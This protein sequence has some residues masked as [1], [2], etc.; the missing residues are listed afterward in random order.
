MNKNIL[1]FFLVL[2]A[3]LVWLGTRNLQLTHRNNEA[4]R[5]WQKDS[6]RYNQQLEEQQTVISALK[7]GDDLILPRDEGLP[8]TLA[9]PYLSASQGVE[10]HL[11]G[12]R[13]ENRWFKPNQTH[14][15]EQMGGMAEVQINQIVFDPDFARAGMPDLNVE[16]TAP[17]F[18]E[19]K[20]FLGDWLE[21]FNLSGFLGKSF[22]DKKPVKTYDLNTT[23]D[24]RHKMSLWLMEFDAF[25]RIEPSPDH[26]NTNVGNLENH[27]VTGI[28]TRKIRSDVEA[29]NQRYGNVSIMLKFKP[30]DGTWYIADRDESGMLVSNGEPKI[31]VGAVECIG[32]KAISQSK[33]LNNIG[34][35]IRRGSSLALY[36]TPEEID[37][38]FTNIGIDQDNVI[39]PVETKVFDEGAIAN[40]HL[41]GS[42]KYAIIHLANLGS[43]QEG[44][45]LSS[46]TRYADQYHARFVIHTYVL[47]EWDVQ[48]ISI[49]TPEPRPPYSQ[50]KAGLLSFLLPDFNLGWFGRILSGGGWIIA[51]IIV[52]SLFFPPVTALV[53]KVLGWLVGLI[54]T[55]K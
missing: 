21:G 53:N 27:P 8:T 6:I 7:P 45:W 4:I 19:M 20:T 51:G 35:Y 25:L 32:I 30:K 11:V 54:P 39:I 5:E 55:K 17:R 52:L 42:E 12:I 24:K 48:P 15:I 14:R 43:W 50:K 9:D 46:R 47:G 49:A 10:V 29:K 37:S 16:V 40:P 36:S 1:I 38:K 28:P 41:F 26:D 44:S 23:P 13:W 34:I 18:F 2:V 22:G 31:G 33:D 3:L